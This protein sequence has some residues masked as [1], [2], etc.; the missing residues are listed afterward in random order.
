MFALC[1]T[2]YV[3]LMYILTYVHKSTRECSRCMSTW[4]RYV[5]S[6]RITRYALG[7]Y[8]EVRCGV[9]VVVY[10]IMTCQS[11]QKYVNSMHAVHYF[12]R[13][14]L[15]MLLSESWL[16]LFEG[17]AAL[18]ILF[19]LAHFFIGAKPWQPILPGFHLHT[20]TSCRR[21][22]SKFRA[23]V[24]I[25]A[26]IQTWTLHIYS[27]NDTAYLL[28]RHLQALAHRSLRCAKRIKW[29]NPTEKQLANR[30]CSI[31]TTI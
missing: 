24:P 10:L 28:K 18:A 14:H 8:N 27:A 22:R 25:H 4:N 20:A 16:M 30:Y 29:I 26:H 2:M 23:N 12:A 13:Y 19:V 3:K 17:H 5:N 9:H 21:K 31:M 6:T 11:W 7:K 1:A 15:S